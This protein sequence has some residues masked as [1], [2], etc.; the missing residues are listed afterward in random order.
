MI[1]LIATAELSTINE[2]ILPQGPLSKHLVACRL[3]SVKLIMKKTATAVGSSLAEVRELIRQSGLRST[4]ARIAVLQRLQ[5]AKTPL[6]HADIAVD[7]V[8]QGFDKA[9]VY[10]NLTDLTEAGLVNRYELGD[11]V[12]RF[13]LKKS[14]HHDPDHPHF[15]CLDCGEITCLSD[16][17]VQI[18]PT[19]GSKK[20]TISELTEVLLKGHCERCST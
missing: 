16:V 3:E 15:L 7:L 14:T 9:T 10:R 17:E 18:T 6:T 19:P 11:H 12:W 20:S 5:G 4:T 8:P 2:W 1:S 13:E